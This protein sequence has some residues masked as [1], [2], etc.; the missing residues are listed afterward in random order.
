MS[1][2]FIGIGGAMIL[3]G[4]VTE[5]WHIAVTLTLVG[6]FAAIYHPV[7]LAMVSRGG[8]D[9]GRRIGVNGVWGN[10]GVAASAISIGLFADFAGWREA[11]LT[12]GLVSIVL[13]IGWTRLTRTDRL[14][15]NA[16]HKRDASPSLDWK[17]VL[18][19][20]FITTTIGGF[21]FNAMTVSM[22]KVLDDRLAIYAAVRHR[23][24]RHRVPGL[25]RGSL[26]P[27]RGRAGHRP[28]RNQADLPRPHGGTGDRALC[29]HQ[30]RRLDDGPRSRCW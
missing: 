17:R 14:A 13:G 23:G 27:G 5:S 15:D 20:V 12:A 24:R 30:L 19:V 26:H 21:I 22:P 4:L 7:G 8:G 11:F 10:M 28:V 3:T 6:M 16:A 29:R 9:V 1:I 25:R 2:F 18:A